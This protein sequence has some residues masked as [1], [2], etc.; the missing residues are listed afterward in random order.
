MEPSQRGL[1]TARL[2]RDPDEV[3][4]SGSNTVYKGLALA[5]NGANP[6]LYAADFH[7][8]RIDVYDG[9]WNPATLSGKFC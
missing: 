2:R 8:A 1:T 9:N 4:N 6:Y 5:S 7:N 3:D